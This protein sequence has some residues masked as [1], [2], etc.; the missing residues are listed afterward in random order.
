MNIV[1][2]QIWRKNVDNNCSFWCWDVDDVDNGDNV[3]NLDNIDNVDNVDN[4]DHLSINIDK[5]ILIENVQY[6]PIWDAS[7]SKIDDNCEKDNFFQTRSKQ[8]LLPVITEKHCQR[9]NGPRHSWIIFP[10]TKLENS[11]ARKIQVK[12]FKIYFNGTWI[13]C[14]TSNFCHKMAPLALVTNLVTRWRHLH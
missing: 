11:V 2:K 7:A 5:E 1:S 14:I 10:A 8:Q 6:G 3:E 9:H 12:Y 4:D 13:G